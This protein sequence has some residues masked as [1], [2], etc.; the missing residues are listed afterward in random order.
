[1]VHVGTA[2][3]GWNSFRGWRLLRRQEREAGLVHVLHVREMQL[4]EM[5]LLLVRKLH[6]RQE[7]L[8]PQPRDVDPA[9]RRFAGGRLFVIRPD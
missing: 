2:L 6:L 8:S 3:P 4:R 5:H 9:A 7:E 1:M